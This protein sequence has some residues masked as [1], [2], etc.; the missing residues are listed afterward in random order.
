MNTIKRNP[1]D[2]DPEIRTGH[3]VHSRDAPGR[4]KPPV[5][6]FR[7]ARATR[8]RKRAEQGLAASL[9]PQGATGA[10]SARRPCPITSPVPAPV[11]PTRETAAKLR[12]DP[13]LR[14]AETGSLDARHVWAAHQIRRCFQ[15]ITA[16]AGVRVT[17]YSDV[18]VH[19]G[20]RPAPVERDT[21]IRLKE[22]YLDWVEAMT[23]A[24]LQLGPV[25]DVVIDEHSLSMTD[26]KWQRRKGWARDHLRHSLD[27][28]LTVT[29]QKRRGGNHE[30]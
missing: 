24:R 13:L 25:L 5:S 9:S 14:L 11:G 2:T 10:R 12:P 17:R 26:R 30:A 18:V 6:S 16:E 8:R 21:E 19:S 15:L 3:P 22:R 4:P 20:P 27:L 28:Y 23:T 7:K 1:S 29:T